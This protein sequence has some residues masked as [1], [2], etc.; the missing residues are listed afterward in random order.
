MFVATTI[1]SEYFINLTTTFDSTLQVY[2]ILGKHCVEC[3]VQQN[4]EKNLKMRQQVHISVVN[5]Q[6]SVSMGKFL[7][8][9]VVLEDRI[10][11]IIVGPTCAGCLLPQVTVSVG[12]TMLAFSRHNVKVLCQQKIDIVKNVRNC[13][14]FDRELNQGY[15]AKRMAPVTQGYIIPLCRLT[16]R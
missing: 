14:D 13:K 12:V 8:N 6:F 2:F 15:L 11:A 7:L 10:I 5:A 1:F 9:M 3:K 16:V 4:I